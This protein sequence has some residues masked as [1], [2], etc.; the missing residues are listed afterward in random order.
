MELE[1][2]RKDLYCSLEYE[3]RNTPL[4][5]L[6]NINTG[7][8]RLFAKEE[9][10]N[11]GGSHYDRVF[12]SLFKY[13][14]TTG[15]IIPGITPVVETTSGSAGA[16]FAYLAKILGYEALV[17]C[18]ENLPASRLMSITQHDA[19]LRLTPKEKYVDGCAEELGRIFRI[20]NKERKSTGLVPYFG[21][22]HTQ[23]IAAE[24][25]A[26]AV[27]ACVEEAVKQTDVSFDFIIAA[28]GNGTTTLGFG[29]AAK[30]R[31]ISLIT[32]ES[33]GSGLYYDAFFGA[34]SFKK[35]F[36]INPGLKHK[37]YGTAFG[38]T[39]YLL[40]NVEKAF[41][42]E[43]ISDVVVVSDEE[44]EKKALENDSAKS[45][46]IKKLLKWEPALELLRE[47]EGK[48][49]GRSSAGSMA[50]VLDLI[51]DCNNKNILTFFYDS[52][53]RY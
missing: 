37:I 52:L 2:S 43:L 25:S 35:E 1:K 3:I 47:I 42:D 9:Y 18:P 50:V 53:E 28:G 44:T 32:W 41:T 39:P 6:H 45:E 23:G 31:G 38:P 40:P 49:V 26:K 4:Y 16:S 5:E 14:E 36:G 7:Q 48:T 24:L 33:L 11:P 46:E 20:E 13:F 27:E 8:N 51:K 15:K 22:N 17:I 34:G 12:T 19:E 30:K 29:T 21:F 10:K